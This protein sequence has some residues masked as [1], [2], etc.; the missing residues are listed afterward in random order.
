MATEESGVVNEAG[1]DIPALQAWLA[2]QPGR[3]VKDF[4]GGT[5]LQCPSEILQVR[6]LGV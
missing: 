6:G 2:E 4:P 1:L 5:A 3:M